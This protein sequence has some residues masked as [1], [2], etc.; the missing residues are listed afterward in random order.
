ML[1]GSIC[2]RRSGGGQAPLA[3][4]LCKSVLYGAFVWARRAPNSQNRRSPARAVWFEYG[5]RMLGR[6]L[7]LIFGLPA[8]YCPRPPGAVKRP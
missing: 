5:H 2:P 1:E 7:G 6:S 4:F 3:F 8:V